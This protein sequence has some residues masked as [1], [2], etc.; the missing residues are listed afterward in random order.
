MKKLLSSILC[1]SLMSCASVS[2][3][4]KAKTCKVWED[5]PVIGPFS[6]DVAKNESKW[7]GRCSIMG[8]F[9]CQWVKS[10]IE[11]NRIYQDS[12]GIFNKRT[13][14]A[15]TNETS[16]TYLDTA[17]SKIVK[18]KPFTIQKEK[19]E[20]DVWYEVNALGKKLNSSRKI[21]FNNACEP[22]QVALGIVTIITAK[23]KN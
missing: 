2:D 9:L 5:Q 8:L 1:L 15:T 11:E 14:I 23:N 19:Q 12:N 16:V 21:Q 22:E 10:D 3:L 17:L 18:V 4:K 6:V 20:V 13:L 7:K